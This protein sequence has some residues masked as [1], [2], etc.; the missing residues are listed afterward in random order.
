[1]SRI[2]RKGAKRVTRIGQCAAVLLVG[3]AVVAFAVKPSLPPAPTIVAIEERGDEPV[4]F[5]EP[6]I[7]FDA[8]LISAVLNEAA[9]VDPKFDEPVNV[10]ERDDEP[11]AP[12]TD[13]EPTTSN[14]RFLGGFFSPSRSL[15]I[16]AGAGK[17]RMAR[18]G[19]EIDFG[20]RV[21]EVTPEYVEIERNGVVERLDRVVAS[22]AVVATATPP[23]SEES[24]LDRLSPGTEVSAS[25]RD[26]LRNARDLA[27]QRAGGDRLKREADFQRRREQRLE[28][29][30]ERGIDIEDD[31]RF[32]DD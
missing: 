3:G 18:P 17:Q 13:A 30:R 12:L 6:A 27:A 24:P 32:Q 23:A 10:A 20:F 1:M 9:G 26:R 22:G 25:A 29:L 5:D 4:M 14:F 19:D 31:D 16:I 11:P 28:E 7:E 21:N 8:V 15:A 2:D